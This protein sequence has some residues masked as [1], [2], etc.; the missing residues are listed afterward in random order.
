VIVTVGIL[1]ALGLEGIRETIS[2]HRVVR[3]ARENFRVEL[4]GNRGKSR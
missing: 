1:I 2:T 3:D 4:Q